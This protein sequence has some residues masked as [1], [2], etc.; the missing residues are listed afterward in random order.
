MRLILADICF[1]FHWIWIGVMLALLFISIEYTGL[2][3]TSFIMTFTTITAQI[4]WLG[5]PILLLEK[6]L[7]GESDSG[8]FICYFLHNSFGI[9][10]PSWVIFVSL[11]G[12]LVL[13]IIL[14]TRANSYEWVK[15]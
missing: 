8:S 11:I 1:W 4:V 13:N 2:R 12:I 7:R 3:T 14:W 15:D 6:K 9:N 10:I 5:C